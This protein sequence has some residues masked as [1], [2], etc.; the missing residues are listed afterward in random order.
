MTLKPNYAIVA[1]TG[2]SQE[3]IVEDFLTYPQALRRLS[4]WSVRCAADITLQLEENPVENH[5]AEL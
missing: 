2:T 5:Q 3:V 4:F 1:F